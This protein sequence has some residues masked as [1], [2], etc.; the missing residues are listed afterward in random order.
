MARAVMLLTC[1]V[2]GSNLDRKHRLPWQNFRLFPQSLHPSTGTYLWLYSPCGPRP[3]FHFLNL[4]IVGRTP[5]S[6]D[7]SVA[8]TLP[9]H[10]TTQTQNKRTSML[11][12]GF[13]PTIPAFERTNTVHALDLVAAVVGQIPKHYLKFW[14]RSSP[15]TSFPIHYSL[16][17]LTLYS[18]LSELLL[19]KIL[20]SPQF[21]FY[22]PVVA[23]I[24]Y[25]TSIMHNAINNHGF[26]ARRL[27]NA[28]N[29]HRSVKRL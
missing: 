26:I 3:L 12:V 6:G 20:L 28:Y 13:E 18:M 25:T 1:Y 9:T 2:P 21:D 24:P 7:Q 29:D 15:S 22:G 4:Y 19:Y 17:I 27:F 5:W 8:R 10:R 14:I 11:W 23:R 16:I